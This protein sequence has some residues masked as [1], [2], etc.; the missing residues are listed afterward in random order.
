MVRTRAYS[1]FSRL[2]GCTQQHPRSWA[3]YFAALPNATCKII[4]HVP[5]LRGAPGLAREF[6]V[7]VI[8]NT[9]EHKQDRAS[10]HHH[11]I[12][13][14]EKSRFTECNNRRKAD[15][16]VQAK[17]RTRAQASRWSYGVTVSVIAASSPTACATNFS[18]DVF[19]QSLLGA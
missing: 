15:D 5:K 1:L 3:G 7:K 9:V 6:T 19:S 17:R 12:T 18:S 10:L 14:R 16:A 8:E 13:V 2:A 11:P 4:E